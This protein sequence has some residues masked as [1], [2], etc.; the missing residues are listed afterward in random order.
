MDRRGIL[1][2]LAAGFAA[3]AASVRGASAEGERPHRLVIHVDQNDPDLMNMAL[4]NA[5]NV[6]D[7][8]EERGE[9]ASIEFVAYAQGLHML[10]EDTS[11]QCGEEGRQAGQADRRGDRRAIRRG[12][13]DG[14]T[15]AGLELRPAVTPI[16]PRLQLA[17]NPPGTEPIPVS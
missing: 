15:G 4:N 17:P 11:Y 2:V 5:G 13:A 3:V 14:A 6:V 7:Y 10:R 16:A 9:K 8:Y 1:G 12:A